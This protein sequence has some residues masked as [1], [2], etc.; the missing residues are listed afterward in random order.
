VVVVVPVV[1]LAVFAMHGLGSP[2]SHAVVLPS[3]AAPAV[4]SHAASPQ[5]G[6][7]HSRDD[8]SVSHAAAEVVCAFAVVGV[9]TAFGWRRRSAPVG[10]WVARRHSRPAGG[11]EPPVPRLAV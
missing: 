4:A 8:M 7:H 6:G 3:A 2:G 10:A 5:Q 1:L 9:W 11:P